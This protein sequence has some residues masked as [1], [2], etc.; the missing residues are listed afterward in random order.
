VRKYKSMFKVQIVEC[1]HLSHSEMSLSAAF[2]SSIE[3]G[4]SKMVC[5]PFTLSRDDRVFEEIRREASRAAAE[6]QHISVVVSR[7]LSQ[8]DGL[9][10]I[11]H[12]AV[13]AESQEVILNH[14]SKDMVRDSLDENVIFVNEEGSHTPTVSVSSQPTK[15]K[16]LRGTLLHC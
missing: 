13:I 4:A 1:A 14:H 11:M 12:R 9:F 3:K 16:K 7:P 6:Y 8:L 15:R 5:M 2:R 10:E